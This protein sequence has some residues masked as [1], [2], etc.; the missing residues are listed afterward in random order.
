[1]LLRVAYGRLAGSGEAERATYMSVHFDLL[2][3]MHTRSLGKAV[4]ERRRRLGGGD[5]AMAE[6][7]CQ[8]EPMLVSCS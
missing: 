7:Y 5:G 1:M 3:C 8:L 2:R 6:L 4:D